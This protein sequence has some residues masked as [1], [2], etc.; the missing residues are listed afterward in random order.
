MYRRQAKGGKGKG[1]GYGSKGWGKGV[2]E[3]GWESG[4]QPA[5]EAEI[6]GVWMIAQVR[7]GPETKVQNRFK[8]L[9]AE[10]EDEEFQEMTIESDDE[11]EELG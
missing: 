2:G 1:K 4:S 3:V 11:D 9:E 7:K 8:E 6:G 5:E 10:E